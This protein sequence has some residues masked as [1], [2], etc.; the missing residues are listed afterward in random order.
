MTPDS[1]FSMI[2]S[3]FCFL[4]AAFNP[5]QGRAPLKKYYVRAEEKDLEVSK[6]KLIYASEPSTGSNLNCTV[7]FKLLPAG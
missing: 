2:R 7:Q 1:L 4:V 6:P 3:Y 5:C